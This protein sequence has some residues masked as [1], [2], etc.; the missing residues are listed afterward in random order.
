M[1]FIHMIEDEV[2]MSSFCHLLM[3]GSVQMMMIDGR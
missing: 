3:K 1:G 2:W